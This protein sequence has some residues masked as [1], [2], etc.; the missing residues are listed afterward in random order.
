MKW[1]AW[2][3]EWRQKNKLD[4]VKTHLVLGYDMQHLFRTGR[5]CRAFINERY[6]YIKIRKDLRA[7]PHGWRMPVAVRVVVVKV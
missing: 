5:L 2:A 3:P 4:G 1:H 7:E 6:G